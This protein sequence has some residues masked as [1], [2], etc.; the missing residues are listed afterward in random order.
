[1]RCC[2]N[3]PLRSDERATP[4]P[5]LPTVDSLP[6]RGVYL[7]EIRQQTQAIY[8]GTPSTF[9]ASLHTPLHHCHDKQRR[10]TTHCA[11]SNPH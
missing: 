7:H 8:S 9:T 2:D 11:E 10:C 4:P 1:M 5:R 3:G 6:K